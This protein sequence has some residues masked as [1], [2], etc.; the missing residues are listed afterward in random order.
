MQVERLQ[1]Q[2]NRGVRAHKLI[3]EA[4]FRLQ[5]LALIG[6]LSE[7]ENSGID[8]TALQDEI[9]GSRESFKMSDLNDCIQS[10]KPIQ[11]MLDAFKNKS[12]EDSQTFAFWDNYLKIVS[13]RLSF[14]KDER[15]GNWELHLSATKAMSPYFFAMNRTNYSDGY[16]Y[17]WLICKL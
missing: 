11:R 4:M 14:L 10:L 9:Q 17:I 2:Y 3:Y 1:K 8:L 15:T 7:Q 6:W 5:W 13:L 12:R 16:L